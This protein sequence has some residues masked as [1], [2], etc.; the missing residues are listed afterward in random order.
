M[1]PPQIFFHLKD[2]KASGKP[3]D[4][5]EALALR[6]HLEKLLTEN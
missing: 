6:M 3:V 1:M 2:L 4:G 5:H